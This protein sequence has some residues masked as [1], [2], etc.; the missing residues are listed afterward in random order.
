[1]SG[2]M[3]RNRSPTLVVV[4]AEPY[5]PEIRHYGRTDIWI[6]LRLNIHICEHLERHALLKDAQWLTVMQGRRP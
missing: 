6:L 4:V 1:M 2:T 5:R 3:V